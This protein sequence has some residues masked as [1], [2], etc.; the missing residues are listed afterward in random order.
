[1]TADAT[2]LIRAFRADPADAADAA[3]RLAARA[4]S[5][6]LV[7][8]AYATV[9]TPL[10]TMTAATTERGL[11]RLALPGY[12]PDEVL[13][14]LATEVSP[15]L[16]E[17]PERLDPLRRELDEYF[18]GSRRAFD[19]ALDWRLTPSG[20]YRRVLRT[21]ARRLPFGVTASYG[22]VAAWA[23]SPGASRAAGTALARNPLP[24]VVPCHRVLRAGGKIGL[25]GGGP[26][27]KRRLLEFEGAVA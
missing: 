15:R 11:V 7:D 26:E 5:E 24:I 14:R 18:D 9:E 1:M 20:F 12:S 2:D 6:G 16:L 22:E 13:E 8:I 19:L 21:A 10:G 3:E 23:G 27:M 25:Y 17:L 4:V